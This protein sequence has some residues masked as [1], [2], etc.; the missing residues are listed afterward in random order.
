MK[1]TV[2]KPVP[3]QDLKQRLAETSTDAARL[4]SLLEFRKWRAV[5]PRD[6]VERYLLEAAE[7]ARRTASHRDLA[8]AAVV[9]SEMLR[10]AG[11]IPGSFEW[12]GVVQ[13]AARASGNPEIEGQ[14]L[15]LVG[16]VKEV[17]EDYQGARDC[18]ERCLDVWRKCGH[19]LGVGAAR[20]QL[21]TLAFNRGH[22]SEALEHYQ[23]CLKIDDELGDI[24]NG[25]IHRYN[26]G[27][28][29]QQLGRLDDAFESFHHVFALSEQHHQI[30]RMRR[31]RAGALNSLGEVFLERDKTAKS[32]GIFRMVIDTAEREK[33]SPA[34]LCEATADLGLAYHRQGD[35]ASAQRAYNQ[36][37]AL[38]EKSGDRRAAAMVI[39][40]MA[41]L[42][43]DL[44][45]LDRCRD[46]AK[47]SVAAAREMELL[48]EEARALRVMALLHAASGEDA[49]ARHCFEQAMALL[50]EL[51]GSLD[52]ARVRFH[53]GR[54]L[55]ALGERAA[56]MTHLKEASR[57][58][59]ELG[60]AADGH[61]VN[62]LLL[63]Q[64]MERDRDMALLQAISGLSSQDVEPRVL[65]ERA[66]ELLLE[67]LRFN[68]AVVVAKGRPVLVFGDPK[69]EPALR[70]CESQELVATD[71]VLSWPVRYGGSL[72]GRIYL[73]RAAP[74]AA[75]RNQ[76]VLDTIANLVAA[77]IQ[78]LAETAA[79]VV[80]G[81]P[82]LAGLRYR[83]VVGQNQRVLEVL[84]T[85][86]AAAG[87][88]LPVL[89][90][91]ERGTGKKLIARALHDSGARV[92]K[93]FVTVNCASVPEDLLQVEFFGTEN[94]GAARAKPYKGKFET[95]DGGTLFL[96]EVGD[97]GPS[98]QPGL[99]RVLQEKT[100]ERVGGRVPVCID[101]RVVVSTTRP[102]EELV[103]QGK[104][105]G[106]LYKRLRAV[107]LLLPSLRERPD[108]I[109][110][111][112][113]HFVRRSS[114]EFG[115]GV[116]CVSPEAMSR[117]RSYGW[118]GN[119][120]ELEHVVELSVL[121]ASGKTIQVSD[122][123]PS[124]QSP[125]G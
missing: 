110:D 112:V 69:L 109:P 102:I 39:A 37:L 125:A 119:V 123:P 8:S 60:I 111:L 20:N 121:L 115:R 4:A 21:G 15:Y 80:E 106:D 31:L 50:R 114:E 74:E 1:T 97:I 66:I 120:S 100:L 56:A 61:E 76:R 75:E 72:L 78:R 103:A 67:A 99:L 25:A 84:A 85:V 43:L 83:G 70:L 36:A 92:G 54:H 58:F 29:L 14:Y 32:I 91:G 10:D 24:A 5:L 47:R 122:L 35:H 33:V 77:P 88:S 64:E 38:A 105:R 46:L 53:Y 62:R 82:E 2:D 117:L 124:L 86:C 65:L 101:V 94:G 49:E 30:Y 28:L 12:A 116:T 34:V 3:I 42:A 16:R 22:V 17:R 19:T 98:L 6:E 7:L 9:L 118:P 52:M 107:E 26:I 108:D 63:R 96:D 79:S 51:E 45:Q 95:A 27:V 57:A 93:P 89:I 23:E 55:L 73:E 41:E 71:L 90:R 48:C 104:F 59:R 81:K 113:C 40:R 68:S 44:G 18:Y 87:G 13:E 11:D